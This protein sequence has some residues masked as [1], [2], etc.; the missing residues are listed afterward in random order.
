MFREETAEPRPEVAT[1]ASSPLRS[2]RRIRLL[3][4]LA[5]VAVVAVLAGIKATQIGTMIKAGKA[6]VPPPEI[7]PIVGET[8]VAVTPADE[9][10]A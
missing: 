2:R 8:L 3:A 5:L 6:M 9:A 1:R 10:A 4:I 7:M